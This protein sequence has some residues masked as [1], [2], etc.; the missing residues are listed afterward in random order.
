MSNTKQQSGMGMNKYTLLAPMIALALSLP[1]VGLAEEEQDLDADDLFGGRG[2]YI[3]PYI[4]AA[5]LYDDNV[6]DTRANKISDYASILSPGIWIA[7]PGVRERSPSPATSPRTAG[8][9]GVVEDRGELLS[10]MGAS[11]HYRSDM[12]RYEEATEND[13]DDQLIEGMLQYSLKGGL[14]FEAMNQY[15][16]SH[17]N[18]GQSIS[19]AFEDYTSNLLGG[20]TTYTLGSRFRLRAEYSN[21]DVDYDG[22]ANGS[23]SRDRNDDKYSAYLFYKLTGKSTFFVE[24]DLVDI[25]YDQTTDLD[26]KEHYYWGGYRWRLSDK[27]MGE[28]KLGYLSQEQAQGQADD[29]GD[30]VVQAWLDYELTGKTRLKIM[31]ARIPEQA[32][33][34]TEQ[35][36]LTNRGSL[37]LSHDL[38]GKI[39]ASVEG[40]YGKTSYDGGYTYQG[41]NG[42]RKDD[43]YTGRFSLDYRIQDWLGVGASYTYF[44]RESSI[45]DLTYTDNQVLVSLTLAM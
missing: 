11:L 21:F 8:G 7:V 41:V 12:T 34:Y 2:G 36:A 27:T 42:E 33:D 29:Q 17:E 38:T 9:L 22:D 14:T 32:D 20:R 40:G 4:I 28:I 3:H 37:T 31:G 5:G 6:N 25:S 43:E 18:P 1:A 35:S 10:R 39:K 44:D 24:Y 15:R 26:S 19:G 16:D 30:F 23:A 45:D 13:S